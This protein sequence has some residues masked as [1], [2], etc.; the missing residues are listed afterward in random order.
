M[1]ERGRFELPEPVKVQRFS[2]PPQST[3]L[4]PLRDN[5]LWHTG[6]A[7]SNR[8]RGTIDGLTEGLTHKSTGARKKSSGIAPPPWARLV[9]RGRRSFLLRKIGGL[10]QRYLSLFGNL[11]YDLQTNGEAFV[12]QRI[13]QFHPAIVFD[14]GANVGAWRITAKSVCTGAE[15]HALEYGRVN[16]L[17]R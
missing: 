3:T 1:A 15:I 12:L 2:R 8:T 16:I 6:V 13:A 14:V 11:N 4:P 5:S 17:S 7:P 10:C 9:A